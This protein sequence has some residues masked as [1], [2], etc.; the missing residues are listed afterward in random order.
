MR[1]LGSQTIFIDGKLASKLNGGLSEMVKSGK[2]GIWGSNPKQKN[3]LSNDSRF[4]NV[5][6]IKLLRTGRDSNPRPPP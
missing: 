4:F 5:F 3:L 1:Y 2:G 6:K